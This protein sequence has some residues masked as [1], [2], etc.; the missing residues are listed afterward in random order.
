MT[1]FAH[2]TV[3]PAEVIALLEPRADGTYAD[4]TLGGGGHA[5]AIL[6]AG[7]TLVG[8]DRDPSALAA[9]KERLARFEGR[10]RFVHARMSEL[11]DVLGAAS[12]DGIVADLGTSSPQLDRA[13]RGFA[14]SK[15]GPLD[16]RMDP[17]SGAPLREMLEDVDAE[18]LANVIY[19][20]GEERRSRPIARSIRRALESG[21]LETTTDLARAVHR[22]TGGKRSSID[23]ATRTFQALRIWVNDELG[24][25]E[26]LVKSAPDVLA[27]EGTIAI[28]SFHSLED[29]MVKHAFRDDPRLVP[30]TKKP[31]VAS[32]EERERN[33]RSR[34]AKLRAARRVVRDGES[35]PSGLSPRGRGGSAPSRKRGAS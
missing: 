20:F 12:V 28:I 2:E 23:P 6:E 17:S 14:F 18:E 21:G 35:G 10:T 1:D 4:V 3:M 26:A 5:E 30:I 25:L 8:F 31:L 15:E 27:D 29:R 7:A 32:D 13:E 11:G 33:P 16:M 22:V 24:E 9:A 19:R 34:S